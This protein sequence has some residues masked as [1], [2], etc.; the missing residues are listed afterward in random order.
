MIC[1]LFIYSK[2]AI[3]TV[4]SYHFYH[5]V[6]LNRCVKLF[7]INMGLIRRLTYV[8]MTGNSFFF[9]FMEFNYSENIKNIL[10]KEREIWI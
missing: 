5:L 2:S 1:D 10:F 7:D 8:V 6:K 3:D 9:I 4:W